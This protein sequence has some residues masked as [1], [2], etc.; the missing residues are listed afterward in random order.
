M[1]KEFIC[2]IYSHPLSSPPRREKGNKKSQ[3]KSYITARQFENTV[4]LFMHHYD[5]NLEQALELMLDLIRKHY[6]IFSEAEK[7]L[8]VTGNPQLDANIKTYAVGCRDLAIGAAF[9]R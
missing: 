2:Q 6:E 4:I 7:R 9:W 3:F 8:P 1:Q 5:L